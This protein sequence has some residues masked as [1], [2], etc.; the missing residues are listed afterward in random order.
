MV[1]VLAAAS[2]QKT[3]LHPLTPLLLPHPTNTSNP[4]INKHS[5]ERKL[6]PTTP[7]RIYPYLATMILTD[8]PLLR[9]LNIHD[10]TLLSL[11]NIYH[12]LTPITTSSMK[13]ASKPI[14]SDLHTI[15]P[16]TTMFSHPVPLAYSPRRPKY[17]KTYIMSKLYQTPSQ[18]LL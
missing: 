10:G 14:L 4:Y 9:T 7:H 2:T 6:F 8:P 3:L 15:Y 18:V 13:L 11:K 12:E 17:Y 16:T 1:S 5:L